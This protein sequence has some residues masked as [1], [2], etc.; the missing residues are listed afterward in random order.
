MDT[1]QAKDT[2]PPSPD[3]GPSPAPAHCPEHGSH[4][5]GLRKVFPYSVR[6][7]ANAKAG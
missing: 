4:K 3:E 6:E 5:D 2:D 1:Y 7:Q